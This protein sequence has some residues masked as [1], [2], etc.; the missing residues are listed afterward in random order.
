MLTMMKFTNWLVAI[1]TPVFLAESSYGAYFL[2]GGLALFTA[3]VLAL[4]M[5]ETRGH[6]L[7]AIQE[8]FQV[9]KAGR[10]VQRIFSG[11][12]FRATR[13][14]DD[15]SSTSSGFEMHGGMGDDA[16]QSGAPSIERS[17]TPQRL[18]L[19]GAA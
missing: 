17:I 3:V 10:Q 19:G 1:T 16:A 2:F 9:P 15:V 7:E 5:P 14:G 18:D 4:F 11:L 12:R 6:S 13:R 8:G